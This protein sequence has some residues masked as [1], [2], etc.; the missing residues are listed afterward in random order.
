MVNLCKRCV[1]ADVLL[2]CISP[3]V[4]SNL[5]IISILNTLIERVKPFNTLLHLIISNLIFNHLPRNIMRHL[6]LTFFSIM[7]LTLLSLPAV[8]LAE[9]APAMKTLLDQQLAT[10][11]HRYGIVGQSVFILKNH[12]P[13]YLVQDIFYLTF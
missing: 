5:T 3:S 2:V 12:Q 8:A 7:V 6:V 9:T 1:I 10:N 13:L 11:G 4:G